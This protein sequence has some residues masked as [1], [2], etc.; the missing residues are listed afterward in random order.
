MYVDTFCL[1]IYDGIFAFLAMCEWKN[2]YRK[3]LTK[4]LNLKIRAH[5]I[6]TF[7]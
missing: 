5:G 7:L 4:P 3:L 2:V 6:P 1:A